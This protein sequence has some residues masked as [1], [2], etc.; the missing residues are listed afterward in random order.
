MKLQQ[1][2]QQQQCGTAVIRTLVA[3]DMILDRPPSDACM[4]AMHAS[5]D[6]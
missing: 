6:Q 4:S 2:Q 1:Q 3:A 5:G